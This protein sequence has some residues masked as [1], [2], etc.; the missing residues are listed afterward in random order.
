MRRMFVLASVMTSVLLGTMSPAHATVMPMSI[1]VTKIDPTSEP[2]MLDGILDATIAAR[3]HT[4]QVA[5]APSSLAARPSA[6]GPDDEAFPALLTVAAEP[7][8]LLLVGT[9][10]A[11]LAGMVRRRLARRR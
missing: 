11:G 10:V 1:L 6:S 9:G 8:T 4:T 2:A 3:A 5:L 7:S